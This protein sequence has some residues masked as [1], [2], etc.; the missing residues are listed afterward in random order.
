MRL[1]TGCNQGYLPRMRDYFVSLERYADFPVEFVTV[2]FE[3]GSPYGKIKP[4]EMAREQ[5]EGAPVETEAIQHGSFLQ[6]ID[7]KA[8]DVLLC[9]D[10]DFVMQRPMDVEEKK[11]LKLKS[12][13]VV[14]SWNGGPHETLMIEAARLFPKCTPQKVSDDWGAIVNTEPIYNVGFLAAQ[15]R[16]WQKI[17]DLYMENWER[18]GQYFGHMARQQWLISWAIADLGLKVKIAPWSF[19]AH[20][21]FGMKP[22]MVRAP[23]GIYHD[24]KLACFRHYL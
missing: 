5:N 11:L 17:Y 6:V 24:G 23:D 22:G 1:I 9:T 10:G 15:K 18:V 19:Y 12:G 16:T 13:E 21:H 8:A 7:A 4:V 14:T 20:G 3:Y 2:G